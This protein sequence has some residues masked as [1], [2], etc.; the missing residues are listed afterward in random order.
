MNRSH[1]HDEFLKLIERHQGI[2]HKV[3]TMYT[4]MEEDRKDLFQ[5]IVYQLWKSYPTFQ[6]KAEFSTWMY[7]VALNTALLRVRKRAK[8]AQITSLQD[9]DLDIPD[10]TGDPDLEDDLR[11]LFRAINRLNEFERSIIMLYLDRKSYAEISGITGL[12]ESAVSVR[13][14]RIK[15]K[16][17]EYL[18]TD[19]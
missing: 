19:V 9:C 4:R 6:N 14:V 1:P 7:R 15:A 2:V 3:C 16:L 11:E 10:N 17:R 5:E 18:G 12:T 8:D 13:L